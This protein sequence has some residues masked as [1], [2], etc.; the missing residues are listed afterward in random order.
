MESIELQTD[1]EFENAEEE[2]HYERELLHLHEA[3]NSVL[4]IYLNLEK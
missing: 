4:R 3:L 2:C 1:L